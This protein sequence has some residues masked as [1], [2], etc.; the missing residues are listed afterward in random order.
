MVPLFYENPKSRKYQ[1]Y[2]LQTNPFTSQI[3]CTVTC[4]HGLGL[5]LWAAV[6][7]LTYFFYQTHQVGRKRDNYTNMHAAND[8]PLL[9]L[10]THNV[11]RRFGL[12]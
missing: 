12:Y 9:F 1:F 3:K 10:F 8:F 2:K 7:P 5:H 4:A 11:Y 6:L